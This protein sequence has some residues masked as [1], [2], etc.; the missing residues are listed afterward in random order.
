MLPFVKNS[1][2]IVL[3]LVTLYILTNG[4]TSPHFIIDTFGDVIMW[5]RLAL[6]LMQIQLECQWV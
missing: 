3:T 4:S 6:A 1:L 2:L 5:H